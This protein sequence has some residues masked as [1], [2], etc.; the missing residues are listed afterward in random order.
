MTESLK[1]LPLVLAETAQP[2]GLQAVIAQ[3]FPIIIL[4]VIMYMLLIR[5]QQKKAKEHQKLTESLKAGDRVV[6]TGGIYGTISGV[7][8]NSIN[9][10]IADGVEIEIARASVRNR[11]SEDAESA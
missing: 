4:L 7:K 3:F 9:L 6:T 8:E 10:K 11:L 2:G 1:A 5:P